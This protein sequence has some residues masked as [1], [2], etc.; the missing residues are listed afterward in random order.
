MADA[1][2][3]LSRRDFLRRAGREAAET[4]VKVVPGAG[5]VTAAVKTSWWEKLALWRRDRAA[6]PQSETADIPDQKEP[7]DAHTDDR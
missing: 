7:S 4:G 5:L 3:P 6:A 2:E 1:P